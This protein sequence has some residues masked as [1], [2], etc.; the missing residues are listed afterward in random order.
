MPKVD[1]HRKSATIHWD[2]DKIRYKSLLDL[3]IPD[4][5]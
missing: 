4:R 3:T 5:D 1:R 2:A